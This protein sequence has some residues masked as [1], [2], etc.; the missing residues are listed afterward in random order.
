MLYVQITAPN[1]NYRSTH[2]HPHEEIMFVVEGEGALL[3]PDGDIPF[4]PG[5][6]F[7]APPNYPHATKSING[8][9]IIS[10]GEKLD[11][12]SFLTEIYKTEDTERGEARMLAETALRYG[13]E[14][15]AFSNACINALVRFALMKRT[16]YARDVYSTVYRII[17]VMEDKYADPSLKACDLMRGSGY[18]EDY[19]RSK[20][21]EVTKL[22]PVK[23]LNHI[24]VK[25]A[26]TLLLKTTLTV[27]EIAQKCGFL[28]M[29][30]FS[31]TFK[32]H[33]G[34]SPKKYKNHQRSTSS[35]DEK[36]L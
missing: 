28:D 21:L 22:S 13:Y 18:A 23:F 17:S 7:I 15:E 16:E 11:S 6:L 26:G 33:F 35:H 25:N 32:S 8:H 27:N 24:R 19:I 34:I 2:T 31:K 14:N 4:H 12:F 10:I 20:F 1:T 9:R 30:Y 29:A 5:C 36:T 3:T